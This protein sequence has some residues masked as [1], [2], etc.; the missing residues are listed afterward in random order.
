MIPV[1]SASP[2]STIVE[3]PGRR[4]PCSCLDR[5]RNSGTIVPLL[6]CSEN[7][8]FH[9]RWCTDGAWQTADERVLCTSRRDR[10]RWHTACIDIICGSRS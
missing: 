3:M 9:R 7:D 10:G 5:K 8:G 4:A 2:M 6:N 1:S